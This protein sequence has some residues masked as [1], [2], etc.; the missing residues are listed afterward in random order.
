MPKQ[1]AKKYYKD[2]KS[3]WQKQRITVIVAI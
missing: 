2:I 1:Y 3:P